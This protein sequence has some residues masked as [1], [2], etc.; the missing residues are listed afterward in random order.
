M[1]LMKHTERSDAGILIEIPL[2]YLIKKEKK[3]FTIRSLGLLNLV[4]PE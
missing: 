1:E 3:K 4:Q 2:F